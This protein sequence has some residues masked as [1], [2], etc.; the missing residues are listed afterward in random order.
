[1]GENDG[2]WTQRWGGFWHDG[3][4]RGFLYGQTAVGRRRPARPIRTR[5]GPTRA[6]TG[7][8]HSS[9]EIRFKINPK[10]IFHARKIDSKWG[11]LRKKFMEVGNPNWNTFPYYIFFQI[12]MNFKI[13][14]RFWVKAGLTEMC[15]YKLI[16]TPIANP[17]EL[18]F[19]Q[20]VHH[21]DLQGLY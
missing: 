19:G 15:S 20:V 3:S 18:H 16:A 2:A 4:D 17:G 5:R 12:S 9:A 21:Y 11:K 14:K 13:F 10:S 6:M 1:M 8:P 7:G